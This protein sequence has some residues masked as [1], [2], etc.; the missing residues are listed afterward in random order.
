M[1]RL[2]NST[3][4]IPLLLAVLLSATNT[5]SAISAADWNA[6]NI[7][8]DT[9]FYD[10]NAMGVNEI[11]SFL[12]A[13][14]PV[15]DTWGAKMYGSITRA[16]WGANNGTP[17][18]FICL[19]DYYENPS[20]HET[21]F[22]PTASIPAGGVSAAQIIYNA[23][24]QYNINPKVL[25]VTIKKEA[26]LNLI[27][28]D[29]PVLSQYRSAMGYACPDSAPCDSQYYGFYNQVQNAARQ[30][31]LYADYPDSYRRKAGQTYAIQYNPDS[32]CGS[33]NV[34]L[35][36][37]ATAGLYN[38]TPYQ[39]NQATIS[40]KL[41][42]GAPVSSSY[43]S[44]GAF[45]NINF[46]TIWNEWFG[47]SIYAPPSSMRVAN[48]T[49][50]LTNP[51]S[52]LSLDVSGGSTANGA[53]VQ[54]YNTNGTAAQNWQLT[55]D[56]E[57]Y[58]SIQNIG[59]GKYLDVSNGSLSP[60]AALQI[61]QG[62]GSCAQKWSLQYVDDNVT[63]LNKCSNYAIDIISGRLTN[64]TKL[65]T[66]TNN[67]SQ[68][69]L[70]SLRSKEPAP[71]ADG[72]YTIKSSSELVLDIAGSSASN[73][74]PIQ[75]G[76][77]SNISSQYWQ[78]F[79][80]ANGLYTLRNPISGR[81]LDVTNASID[82]G[83][84]LQIWQNTFTC[85]QKW[86]ITP[87]NQASFTLRSACSEKVIDVENG[88]IST[89]G[90]PIQIWDNN[91]TPAQ[92]WSF[93]KLANGII[94]TGTYTILDQGGK[95][96]DIISGLSASGTRLQIWEPNST[97]AQQWKVSGN[98]DGSYTISNVERN[99]NIDIMGGNFARSAAVQTW[100]PN[101]TCAQKWQFS[102]TSD[103]SWEILPF[104]ATNLAVDITN[105][106]IFTNGTKLQ[107]YTA[108]STQAQTWKFGNP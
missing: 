92:A 44:C 61:W 89:V 1:K 45:G 30:F 23:A 81:Y 14:V 65:Q 16:Q 100:E 9:Y 22:N 13:L 63:I 20:T 35:Q 84:N 5:S 106:A 51:A 55:R 28:D 11:Q 12:N 50:S 74:A 75:L 72:F 53:R 67:L 15:C 88:A 80:L 17:A 57:G 8:S 39:P 107:L 7:I 48:G 43:P 83:T 37:Q 101:D 62:N 94:P 71:V 19:K 68:A 38:Y 31:R 40:W 73:G 91:Q 58:Y 4:A 56:A 86:D 3:L 10:G 49:Y 41:S 105:G 108:N 33:S 18:P 6:G 25:L 99:K 76:N 52:G 97:S 2:L 69:Q 87:N 32:R 70:W 90:T 64:G 102:A 47:S 26:A 54:I 36:S 59:S 82:S 42:G 29:W 104:C 66:W 96:I 78:L 98:S 85:A 46:W 24:Q 93:T 21:N 77:S 79:R 34:Y 60:G 27:A 95:A 103:S